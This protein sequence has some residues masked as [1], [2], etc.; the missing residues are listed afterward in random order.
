[1]SCRK[2]NKK[3]PADLVQ[4]IEHFNLDFV[5]DLADAFGEERQ[6]PAV[7][8]VLVEEKHSLQPR[9]FSK[10][11]LGAWNGQLFSKLR[12]CIFESLN[13]KSVF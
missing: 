5:D 2:H 9:E 6:G 8:L 11:V 4:S 3:I 1:M 7:L 10:L 12:Q 13:Q